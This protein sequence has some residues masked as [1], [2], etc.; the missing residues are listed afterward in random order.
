MKGYKFKEIKQVQKQ[1]YYIKKHIIGK[2]K[3]IGSLKLAI[4]NAQE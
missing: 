1:L 4:E 2:F 3:K